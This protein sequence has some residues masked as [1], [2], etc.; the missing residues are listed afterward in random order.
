MILLNSK[1]EEMSYQIRLVFF[2]NGVFEIFT[3]TQA[4]SSLSQGHKVRRETLKM[5]FLIYKSTHQNVEVSGGYIYPMKIH[6]NHIF[7]QEIYQSVPTLF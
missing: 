2:I 3:P 1:P 7:Y 6:I 4:L 5:T